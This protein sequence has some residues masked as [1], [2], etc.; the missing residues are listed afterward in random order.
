[1]KYYCYILYSASLDRFYTGA[2]S[3]SVNDRL[4]LHLSEFYGNNKFTYAA[5]DWSIFLEIP[6]SSYK[7]AISIEK[8]I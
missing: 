5:K 7:Q 2:T 6:C 1:M 8:H 3:N 4:N